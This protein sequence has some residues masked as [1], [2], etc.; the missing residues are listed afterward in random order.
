M[1]LAPTLALAAGAALLLCWH[2]RPRQPMAPGIRLLL[3]LYAVLGAWAFCF[4]ATALAAAQPAIVVWWKPTVLYWGLCAVLLASP[5]LGWGY[6]VKAVIGTY[7]V[8]SNREW[9]WINL[10]IALVCAIL[11]SLNLV[12]V[13]FHTD[14]DWDGFKWSCMVNVIAVLLLRVTFVWV[15]L[16]AR[17]ARHLYGRARGLPP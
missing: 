16:L 3:A 10:A 8:F 15:D 6:P 2:W 17:I 11:G 12:I 9:H 4:G 14:D 1:T 5:A 7:F 13:Y